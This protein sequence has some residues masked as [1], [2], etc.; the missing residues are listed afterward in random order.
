MVGNDI[1]DLNLADRDAW[2]R[3]R[4]RDKVFTGSE[5]RLFQNSNDPG[6]LHWILWSM[7]ESAYKLHVREHFY[8]ALNPTKF[9]CAFDQ[10]VE[11]TCGDSTQGRVE[12]RIRVGDQI[13][14]TNTVFNQDCI[15]TVALS[16]PKLTIQ[17]DMVSVDCPKKLRKAVVEALVETCSNPSD[18]NFKKV[19]FHKDKNGIPFVT[20]EEIG[21]SKSCS[22][23]HH[24]RFG[25][26]AVV[27]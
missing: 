8:R 17:G 27:V 18:L 21:V 10:D 1:V 20:D 23:S 19:K 5:Q 15:H 12:G 6:T 2:K 26:Y 22:I 3:K 16:N 25:A 13:F 7:K 24:G 14:F 11:L 9:I 4:Y